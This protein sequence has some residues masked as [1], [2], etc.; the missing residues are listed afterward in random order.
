M[1]TDL[2]EYV[3]F[4]K[5]VFGL[6]VNLTG[7]KLP[8]K[9]KGFSWLVFIAKELGSQPIDTAIIACHKLFTVVGAYP[10]SQADQTSSINDRDPRN[11]SYAIRVGNRIEADKELKGLSDNDI[12]KRKLV[13]MTWLERLI[14]ELFH[15]WKTKK[16]L[17]IKNWTLCSGSRTDLQNGCIPTVGWDSN[18]FPSGVFLCGWCSP[19]CQQVGRK[20]D[21][22]ARSVISA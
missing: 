2:K 16:H 8:P 6:D 1:R 10:D 22:R 4:Y 14:L 13:T 20:G 3:R 9:T 18:I 17:D 19:D 11:G 21:L 5:E 12:V 15:F 7:V